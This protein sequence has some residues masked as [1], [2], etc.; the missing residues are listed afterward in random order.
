MFYVALK[1]VKNEDAA[2]DIVHSAFIRII[3]HIEKIETFSETELKGYIIYI[4]KNLAVDS[5]RLHENEKTVSLDGF[6]SFLTSQNETEKDAIINIS[7]SDM[8][9]KLDSLDPKYSTAVFH[10]YVLGYSTA[11]VAE[12]LSI[13]VANAKVRCHRGRMMLLGMLRGGDGDEQKPL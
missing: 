10:K 3:K 1:I 9:N 8:L 12:I 11:E 13:S 7:I 2:S 5:V 4:V 6:E